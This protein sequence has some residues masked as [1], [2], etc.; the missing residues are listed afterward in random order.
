MNALAPLARSLQQLTSLLLA[1]GDPQR[2]LVEFANLA[3]QTLDPVAHCGITVSQNGRPRTVAATSDLATEVDEAQYSEGDGPCLESLR[4]GLQ[5]RVADMA[6]ESRWGGFP[7]IAVSRQVHSSMSLPLFA[8]NEPVGVLN[9]Y[10]MYREAFVGYGM[11]GQLFAAQVALTLVAA[12]R[13]TDKSVLTEQL[14]TALS[15][16]AVIDQAIGIVMA[17][18]HCS[19]EEGFRLLVAASQR[20]NVKVR[21]IA[22]NIVAGAAKP[23]GSPGLDASG[24]SPRPGRLPAG[25]PPPS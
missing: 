8:E 22:E 19:P 15:S 9:L 24:R 2:L 4:T 10:G 14:Q 12:T 11:L 5:I 13:Y 7:A 6:T 17:S 18:R 21:I 1:D 3:V 25:E 16:R 20:Q 23:T